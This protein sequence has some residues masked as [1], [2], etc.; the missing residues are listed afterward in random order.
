MRSPP[1]D[2]REFLKNWVWPFVNTA[3]TAAIYASS[4][5]WIFAIPISSI[6]ALG[7]FFGY[8]S[9]DYVLSAFFSIGFVVAC[10]LAVLVASM[11]FI[12]L[13][14]TA[15]FVRRRGESKRAYKWAG[16]FGGAAVSVIGAFAWF[17]EMNGSGFGSS[18]GFIFASGYCAVVGAITA[19]LWW[20][21]ARDPKIAANGFNSAA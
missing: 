19:S 18:P 14:V 16:A 9:V 7:L 13:P 3:V 6:W 8:N 15:Y 1:M 17:G 21:N 11:T 10:V 20:Q 4:P 12:G 5:F 2:W